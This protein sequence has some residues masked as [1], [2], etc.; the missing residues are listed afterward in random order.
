MPKRE[1]GGEFLRETG[2]EGGK[3]GP[4]LRAIYEWAGSGEVVEIPVGKS[5][6]GAGDRA[7][8]E[9]QWRPSISKWGGLCGRSCGPV[10][11]SIVAGSASSIVPID[12]TSSSDLLMTPLV[13]R[14]GTVVCTVLVSK[15][16]LDRE[17]LP[18]RRPYALRVALRASVQPFEHIHHR[19]G[20]ARST[21]I[22][23]HA[24]Y[25]SGT[26]V[27]PCACT[28]GIGLC[29]GTSPAPGPDAVS[30]SRRRQ[31]EHA[32]S[33]IDGGRACESQ[34]RTSLSWRVPA[35]RSTRPLACSDRANMSTPAHPSRRELGGSGGSLHGGVCLKAMAVCITWSVPGGIY[36]AP[37]CS[38]ACGELAF[39]RLRLR[40]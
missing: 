10:A 30:A 12:A 1:A 24:G 8:S 7:A 21:P 16:Y 31:F 33:V 26:S 3:S 2:A 40:R 36:G 20:I 23:K 25:A 11:V 6:C 29:P 4:F 18:G 19:P 9:C 34:L 37:A 15:L 22:G 35:V 39:S 13:W 14:L 32:V 17:A 28:S 38:R 5:G 27:Q